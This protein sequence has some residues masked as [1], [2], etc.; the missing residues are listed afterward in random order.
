MVCLDMICPDVYVPMQ[1]YRVYGS[2]TVCMAEYILAVTGPYTTQTAA[3]CQL[4]ACFNNDHTTV[5]QHYTIT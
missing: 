1:L 5:T 3:P 2:C 4:H